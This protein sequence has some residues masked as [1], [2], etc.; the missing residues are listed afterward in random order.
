MCYFSILPTALGDTHHSQ[1]KPFLHAAARVIFLKR[2]GDDVI[3]PYLK[4]SGDFWLLKDKNLTIKPKDSWDQP[5]IP[6]QAYI[7]V[8][9]YQ[10]PF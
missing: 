10:P 3:P 4:T 6:F 1:S 9:Y 8:L 2:D 7:W 5:P